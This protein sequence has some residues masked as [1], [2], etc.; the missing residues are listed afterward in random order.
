MILKNR[1]ESRFFNARQLESIAGLFEFSNYLALPKI[2]RPL[3]L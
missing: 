3:N 2:V 1:L